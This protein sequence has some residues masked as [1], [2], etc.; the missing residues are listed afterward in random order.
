[1]AGQGTFT[2][3]SPLAPRG[4]FASWQVGSQEEKHLICR[5]LHRISAL[6]E[7]AVSMVLKVPAAEDV[8]SDQAFPG[9]SWLFLERSKNEEPPG[10]P[11]GSIRNETPMLRLFVAVRSQG[12]QNSGPCSSIFCAADCALRGLSSHYTDCSQSASGVRTRQTAADHPE[13]KREELC[14][15]GS[16][17]PGLASDPCDETGFDLGRVGAPQFKQTHF[18]QE[19][20]LCFPL[21]NSLAKISPKLETFKCSWADSSHRPWL[22]WPM[23]VRVEHFRTASSW[24]RQK[25]IQRPDL[26]APR[27]FCPWNGFRHE[28]F[29]RKPCVEGQEAGQATKQRPALGSTHTADGSSIPPHPAK[30]ASAQEAAAT[31]SINFFILGLAEFPLL[32]DPALDSLQWSG[33]LILVPPFVSGKAVEIGRVSPAPAPPDKQF[34]HTHP[35]PPAP[36]GEQQQQQQQQQQAPPPSAPSRAARGP[37]AAGAE[38]AAGLRRRGVLRA[39]EVTSGRPGRRK[40]QAGQRWVGGGRP[41]CGRRGGAAKAKPSGAEKAAAKQERKVSRRA[42]HEEEDLEALIAEFRSLDAQKRHVVETPCPPPSPRLNASLSSHPEKDELILFGGEYFNGQKVKAPNEGKGAMRGSP[43]QPS[44]LKLTPPPRFLFPH[45]YPAPTQAVAVAQGGGQLWIFGGEFASPDGEQF[46]HYR[47]LWVLHLASRTWEQIRAAGAP[48]GRSGHR[49]VACRR[50]LIVFG[51]FHE[52]AR[53]YVYYGDVHAFSLETFAWTKLT[54]S[55]MAPAPRSG[56]H[57]AATPEGS[58]VVYGGYSKQRI[59]KDVDRGTLHTDMFLLKAAGA[60]KWAWSRINP[61]GVKPTPRS[62]FSVTLGPGNRSILFGGVHDEE[63]EEHLE[64]DFYNDLYFYDLAKSRWFPGL[65]KGPKSERKKR[66]RALGAEGPHAE[67]GEEGQAPPQSPVEIVTQVVAEDGTVTTI[68]QVLSDPEG[69][70]KATPGLEDEED[71]EEAPGQPVEPCPR[72]HA[73]LAVKQGVLYVYGGMF[74]V[75]DR[76]FT[77]S[78]FYALDLHKM[79]SWNVLVEMDPETQEWLEES[80]S[81]EEGSVEGAEGGEEEEEEEEE[82]DDDDNDGS[83]EEEE[84]HPAVQPEETYPDYLSRTEQ[85]WV[86][87]ARRNMG[88]EAKEKKTVRVGHAMAKAFYEELP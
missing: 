1:M 25:L 64:G 62:G 83:E 40:R 61:S 26:D 33:D 71:G 45:P 78:D 2:P 76:Q 16:K 85:Y 31:N 8:P 53:D 80:E 22:L 88:P 46:Y 13:L 3:T 17:K 35:P 63:E 59:K 27:D 81:E 54:P 66:R 73:M 69:A 21:E 32:S 72:S 60:D 44:A 67:G 18:K 70:P 77:L 10:S 82:E 47:D 30:V 86:Q 41:T 51:G 4:H 52:S 57:L 36:L 56:C 43:K 50:Q 58:V 34:I 20:R 87:L 14:L 42:R 65:V 39:T 38:P 75:G 12:A 5:T 37:G 68:K 49:M 11:F 79:D 9:K 7:A 55:G 24:E 19:E 48:S 84:G 15:A 6:S 29:L 23:G 74:E 28:L